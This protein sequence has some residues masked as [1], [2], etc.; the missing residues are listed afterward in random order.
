MVIDGRRQVPGAQEEALKAAV[1]EEAARRVFPPEIEFRT[2][3]DR[4]GVGERGRQVHTGQP[5]ACGEHFAQR[6]LAD[7]SEL[8][9][10]VAERLAAENGWYEGD[11]PGRLGY[12]REEITMPETISTNA[13]AW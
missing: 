11:L 13:A 12:L 2:R 7:E 1:E 5:A 3:G 6:G 10:H 9:Q 4:V 8:D